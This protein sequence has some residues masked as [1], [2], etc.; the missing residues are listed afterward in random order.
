MSDYLAIFKD[1][2][3]KDTGR[4]VS[5]KQA[6][7]FGWQ[8]DKAIKAHKAAGLC[9]DGLVMHGDSNRMIGFIFDNGFVNVD[10]DFY[11]MFMSVSVNLE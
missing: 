2:A 3:K 5:M 4:F 11:K 7:F 8:L 9:V 1:W 10:Y 6:K